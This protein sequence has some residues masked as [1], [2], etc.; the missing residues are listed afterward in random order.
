MFFPPDPG[1]DATI[2]GMIA[3]NAS[4]VRTVKYG[5]TKDYVMRLVVVLPDG[6]VIHT[7]CRA[8]K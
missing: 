3:N 2:G 5:A 7:G 4:G 8:P 1:A 6:D